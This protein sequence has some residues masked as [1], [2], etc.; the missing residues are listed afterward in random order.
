[1]LD[2]I[3]TFIGT[4]ITT[5][6]GVIF[7]K[8]ILKEE[9][10]TKFPYILLIILFNSLLAEILYILGFMSSKVVIVFLLNVIMFK[11]TF[12]VKNTKAFMLGLI[13]Y[14]LI[15][16]SEIVFL[17]FITNLLKLSG[18]SIYVQ[19]GAT[20][21]GNLFVSIMVLGL[22]YLLRNF[23]RLLTNIKIKNS[24]LIYLGW[25]GFCILILLIAVAL[26]S[27]LTITTFVT[28]GVAITI[29]VT[30]F[31]SLK[32]SYKH[33]ELTLKYDKLLE[34]IKKYELEIDKQRILRHE[35]RNQFVIIK[36]KIIDKDKESNI[37]EYINEIIEDNNQKINN[38][39]Y[40]KLGYLPSNGIKGLFY[41]KV[42]EASDKGIDIKINISKHVEKCFL[43]KLSSNSFNQVGKVLGIFLDN[44]IEGALSSDD[45]QLGLEVYCEDDEATFIISN[46]Y[47]VANSISTNRRSTKGINR[48]HGLLLAEQIINLNPKLSNETTVTERVYVQKLTIKK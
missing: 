35:T 19:Y 6:S 18:N 20:L 11:I 8:Y 42:S 45:K 4:V 10:K 27:N 43:N 46:T 32:Q 31:M 16:A 7:G 40:S 38:S 41:F 34:F 13:F 48:G 17:I 24:F 14:L 28:L 21:F 23:L 25:S 5:S 22:G 39:E 1:M 44:A 29:L 37:I 26:E 12:K 15:F 36:S 9:I 30:V 3:S 33:H 47:L 2:L